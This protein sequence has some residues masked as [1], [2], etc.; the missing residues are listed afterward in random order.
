MKI[1]TMKKKLTLWIVFLP[2]VLLAQETEFKNGALTIDF[3][4]KKKTQT[5]TT[6]TLTDL[7]E[8]ERPKAK[9]QKTGYVEE[10]EE[11]NPQRD[12]LFKATFA[13]GLNLSQIDGDVQAGYN[14]PGAQAAVGVLVKFHKNVSVGLEVQYAMKGAY[15]RLNNNEFPTSMFRQQWDYVGIPLM[16]NVHDKKLVMAS[17]GLS[18]N[19]LVRNKLR[20]DV[21]D[22][23]GNIDTTQSTVA[24]QVLSVEPK[25]FDLCAVVGFQFLIK[26]VLGI[27][28][29]FEYSLIGL[30][31]SLGAATKVRNMYNNTVTVRLQ[32]ILSPVKKKK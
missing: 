32:Y 3:G 27:G 26:K 19:Y 29:R 30:K 24:Y 9:K 28:A 15:K 6:K 16:L 17:A 8:E 21:Y 2:F 10:A 5:D 12:G 11:F 18:F 1:L 13:T 20:Y 23:A 31:P 4:K 7:D 25:K 22:S 14:Y